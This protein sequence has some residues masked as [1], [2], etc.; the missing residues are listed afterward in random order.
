MKSKFRFFGF[1]ALMSVAAFTVQSCAKDYSDEIDDL[2]AQIVAAQASITSLQTAISAGKLVSSVTTV[3]NGYKLN[4]SDGTSVTI[5][6]GATGAT[7]PAGA[8]GFTPIIGI[9]AQGY[10]TVIQTQGGTATR[11]L[12][13]GQ[14]V[15]AKVTAQTLTL[16]SDKYLY[17]D[18][19]KTSVTIPN[20]YYNDA[21][22]TLSVWVYTN[23]VLTEYKVP[24][25][26]DVVLVSDILNLSSPV[27]DTRVL[28][29]YGMV[30]NYSQTSA[31]LSWAGVSLGDILIP[32]NAKL[33]VIVNPANATVGGYTFEIITSDGNAIPIQ[34]TLSAGWTGDF[35][36]YNTAGNSG[37]YTLTLQP[38][39][40][41]IQA[42][43]TQFATPSVPGMGAATAEATQLAVRAM[44]G[45][46]QITSP[47]QYS[48]LVKS[49]SNVTLTAK[50]SP[51]I[52]LEIP[53]TTSLLTQFYT[54]PATDFYK[55]GLEK[56]S[57]DANINDYLTYGPAS[58]SVAVVQGGTS[59][60]INSYRNAS[61]KVKTMDFTGKY[62]EGTVAVKFYT[63]LTLATVPSYSVSY[64]IGGSQ[65]NKVA[66]TSLFTALDGERKLE[67]WRN[68]AI[69]LTTSAL[70]AGVVAT[71]YKADGTTTT[72]SPADVAYVGFTFTNS[73]VVP[74]TGTVV[75]LKFSDNRSEVS[76]LY[77]PFEVPVTITV[78]NP[79]LTA[80]IGSFTAAH[81][82]TPMWDGQK[83]TLY[84]NNPSD[85]Y[86]LKDAY[87]N[88]GTLAVSPHTYVFKLGT[89]VLSGDDYEYLSNRV[90]V[91]NNVDLKVRV[92]GN[93]NNEVLIETIQVLLLSEIQ[94]GSV[95]ATQTGG[96]DN[97]IVITH[98]DQTSGYGGWKSFS[99][100]YSVKDYLGDAVN[101]FSSS[102]PDSRLASNPDGVTVAASG[103]NAGLIV[104]ENEEQSAPWPPYPTTK[105]TWR[106]RSAFSYDDPIL[107]QASVEVPVTITITDDFGKTLVK[108]VFVKVV[109]P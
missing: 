102:N 58:P 93:A 31:Q 43:L 74:T 62:Q 78:S 91:T 108:N 66:L 12:V 100:I 26:E 104:I 28:V 47:Y 44:K 25:A 51:N 63:P 94:Q 85:E 69:N 89:N 39:S 48:M 49:A 22:R 77:T 50:S 80:L 15:L 65:P 33:P 59:E 46:R 9:D 83:I 79:S 56:V 1:V 11:I 7:G 10:W 105:Y 82:P 45:T 41:N 107:T 35:V 32:A 109:K 81:V 34:G 72:T 38:T 4:F 20:I 14:P 16:G 88:F 3:T 98:G 57:A 17:I 61:F 5:T 86:D 103:T 8:T 13:G 37:L 23:S 87:V 52:Y 19:V 60:D 2:Q 67:L 84:G 6:N 92:Y 24:L 68:R 73:T 64:T 76:S 40:A 106:V 54:N 18:G 101:S 99:T 70:P 95:V 36:Q 75:K 21:S 27:A 90:N 71:F 55:V 42:F 96:V 97:Q 29:N 30:L 53:S